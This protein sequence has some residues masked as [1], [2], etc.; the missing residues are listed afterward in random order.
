[1][2]GWNYKMETHGTWKHSTNTIPHLH[3][4]LGDL[5]AQVDSACTWVHALQRHDGLPD[6]VVTGKA[7]EAEDQEV[8]RELGQRAVGHAVEGE[9]L[10][11][12]RV[13]GLPQHAGLDTVLFLWQ[14]GHLHIGVRAACLLVHGRE[15]SGPDNGHDQGLLG[16]V[17]VNGEADR[18][19]AGLRFWI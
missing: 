4:P 5:L 2:D 16:E 15:A 18:P 17:V 14:D 7:V 3:V 19:Q 8:Q 9:G 13:Q 1:M 12:Q 6:N 10:V 11:K